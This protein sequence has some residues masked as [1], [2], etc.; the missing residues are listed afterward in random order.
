LHLGNARTALFSALL[1]HKHG[2]EFIL[3]IE[4]TD[5][6]R[7]RA[8]YEAAIVADLDWLG[9]EWEEGPGRGGARG[10][11]RQ[12]ERGAI[13][14]E[15]FARLERDERAY[16]CF[17]TREEL[18]LAR[19]AQL[20]AGKPP[21]YPGTCADL[22]EAERAARRAA[23]REPTL[24]FRVPQ[25]GAIRFIDLVRG[26]QVFTT[27][28]IGDFVIRR[29]DGSP[30]F[31]FSNAVDDALM[32]ITHVLRGEDHLA[33]T[34]RQLLPLQS[35]D[36]PAPRYGHLGLVV[37]DDGAPL[38][39]RHGSASLGDLRDE[40]F[41]AG[42]VANYLARLGQ[43]LQ[44][45]RLMSLP[46]LARAFDLDY[47]GRAPAHFDLHQLRHWQREAIHHAGDAELWTWLAGQDAAPCDRRLE[48]VPEDKRLMFVQTVRD[49]I[50]CPEDAKQWAEALFGDRDDVT[51]AGRAAIGEAGA[52]YYEK[53][54]ECLADEPDFKSYIGQLKQCT[55]LKGPALYM[56]L[57]A[58]L[59]GA[60][61]GPELARIWTLL[62]AVRI[63]SRLEA[64]LSVS[65]RL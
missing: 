37:G 30:A 52:E 6:A 21:R 31:F 35:L 62:G 39:K 1:A 61:H 51:E 16:P 53:A 47:V 48:S 12:S 50:A 26:E 17:C 28:T 38:A 32:E 27:A 7:V 49:N 29:A 42:A 4:D 41:L 56:P 65:E 11:Y 8:D 43:S 3:R 14:R 59:T 54:L 55:S 63:R 15:H 34:P 2:G 40:G 58:A 19:K 10:P 20:A 36:L 60:T 24:R 22:S 23:G 9:I 57:R 64:A 18:A 25:E 45:E 13:Y 46:E 5:A 44:E 33:N